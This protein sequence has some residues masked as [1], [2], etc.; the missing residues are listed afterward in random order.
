MTTGFTGASTFLDG[1]VA[2]TTELDAER[3]AQERSWSPLQ[4]IEPWADDRYATSMVFIPSSRGATCRVEDA[5]VPA[6][7]GQVVRGRAVGLPA[8]D[9]QCV[10]ALDAHV[11][12]AFRDRCCDLARL[13]GVGSVSAPR[14]VAVTTSPARS[15]CRWPASTSSA[16]RCNRLRMVATSQS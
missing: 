8:A 7:S 2:G 6:V 1:F 12:G 14:T 4:N 11:L 5:K 15:V 16:A 10:D 3:V 9:H 13:A